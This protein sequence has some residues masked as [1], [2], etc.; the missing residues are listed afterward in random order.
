[1]EIVRLF[2]SVAKY[3]GVVKNSFNFSC[4]LFQRQTGVWLLFATS[5]LRKLCDGCEVA[6]HS[7]EASFSMQRKGKRGTKELDRGWR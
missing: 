6:V 3:F 7:C 4:K 2:I 5:L 1:M